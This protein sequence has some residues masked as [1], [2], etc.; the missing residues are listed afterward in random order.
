[1]HQ[2]FCQIIPLD[3][4]NWE[5][6]LEIEMEPE[7]RAFIPSVLYSLAQAKFEQL[8]PYGIM[9]H[10]KMVGF[11]MYGNFAGICW[12]SRV[13]IDKDYQ[14]Q[15]IGRTAVRQLI[16]VMQGK[17]S[18]KE[19]RTSY[20]A[21]NHAAATFFAKLGFQPL[22]KVLGDEVVAQYRP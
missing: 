8:V 1:M 10:G 9:H 13:I 22:P 20:Q 3:R 17:I 21:D 16:E 4:Y 5:L 18:C 19:I 12:I 2:A 7:Q 14:N 11:I 15:G 6:C